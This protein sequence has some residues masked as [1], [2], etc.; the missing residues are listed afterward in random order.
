MR[1]GWNEQKN[2]PNFI[3]QGISVKEESYSNDNGDFT[4]RFTLDKILKFTKPSKIIILIFSSHCQSYIQIAYALQYCFLLLRIRIVRRG[5]IWHARKGIPLT[6]LWFNERQH[7]WLSWKK[8]FF[9]RKNSTPEYICSPSFGW[10][11]SLCSGLIL[12]Q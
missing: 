4:C 9:R 11:R 6:G 1:V 3:P 10:L 5:Y 8:N 2:G 7:S 12:N